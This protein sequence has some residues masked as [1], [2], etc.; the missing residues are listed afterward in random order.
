MTPDEV[1]TIDRLTSSISRLAIAFERF[2]D[3]QARTVDALH[4]IARVLATEAP[5]PDDGRRLEPD[6]VQRIATQLHELPD[7][8]R[9]A[10]VA[11]I[12]LLLHPGD[13]AAV[14]DAIRALDGTPKGKISEAIGAS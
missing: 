9:A 2:S 3:V 12:G 11:R 6:A 14:L 4:E 10:A 8:T 5:R 13:R 7:S 1:L